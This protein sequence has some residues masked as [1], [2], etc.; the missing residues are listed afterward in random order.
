MEILVLWFVLAVVVAIV[1][2]TRGRIAPGWFILSAVLSPVI[3]FALLL[4]LPKVGKAA[5]VKDAEGNAITEETHTRCPDCKELVR[6]D[7]RKCKHCG[8]DLG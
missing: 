8:S 2:E 1:A 7:A 5:R 6:I 4:A 3:S